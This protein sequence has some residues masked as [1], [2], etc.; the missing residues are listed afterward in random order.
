M[1]LCCAFAEAKQLQAMSLDTP[2]LEQERKSWTRAARLTH[3]AITRG[4]LRT[5]AAPGARSGEINFNVS[6]ALAQGLDFCPS[7][8]FLHGS[9]R[10]LHSRATAGL[11]CL[12]SVLHWA[13]RTCLFGVLH[14]AGRTVP[15][16]A[17]HHCG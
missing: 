1:A 14:W 15:C 12:F 7:I 13:G 6:L 9:V 17:G 5:A 8:H 3:D 10:C 16:G 4:D 2:G 11:P